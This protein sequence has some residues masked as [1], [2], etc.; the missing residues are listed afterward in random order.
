[1]ATPGAPAEATIEDVGA[2]TEASYMLDP[3]IP[4]PVQQA[5]ARATPQ[6]K[7]NKHTNC[8][9][10]CKLISRIIFSPCGRLPSPN[11]SV[12]GTYTMCITMCITHLLKPFKLKS[13]P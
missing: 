9:L 8:W 11:P 4:V 5:L 10:V 6:T 7:T 13:A 12:H 3:G 1:M 2:E